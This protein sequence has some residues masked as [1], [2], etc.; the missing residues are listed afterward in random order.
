MSETKRAKIHAKAAKAAWEANIPKFNIMDYQAS[1]MKYLNFFNVEVEND[2]K[3][4]W[5]IAHWKS[6]GKDVKNLEK[7]NEFYYCQLG[8]LVQVIKHGFDLEDKHALLMES[9]YKEFYSQ[10]NSTKAPVVEKEKVVRKSAEEKYIE[11]SKEICSEIDYELDNISINEKRT[12]NV[13]NL[14]L[15]KNVSQ[16]ACKLI[17]DFYKRQIAEL[18]E[19]L[20]AKNADLKEGYSHLSKKTVRM[21]FD[22][23][24]DVVSFSDQTKRVAVPRKKKEKPAAV[25]AA[26]VKYLEE[27]TALGIKSVH[28]SKIVGADVVYLFNVKLR[29][30][31]KYVAIDNMTLTLKGTTL[32][33]FSVEKSGSKTIRKPELFFG[34]LSGY[35]DMTKRPFNKLFDDVKS[36]LAK[37]PGRISSDMLILKTF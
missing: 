17:S 28:P 14:I 26:K 18:Q 30:M 6:Q 15:G 3:R 27:D 9:K 2:E 7:V 25:V 36:V 19:V 12:V 20:L 35:D 5:V 13:K 32:L 34:P 23:L 11:Q 24:T 31:F 37:A 8:V 10:S 22:F 33:N 21:M 16:G 4:K 29:K 1:L